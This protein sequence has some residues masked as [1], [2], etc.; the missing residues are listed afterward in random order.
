MELADGD[1]QDSKNIGFNLN[2]KRLMDHKILVYK[3]YITFQ[4][5]NIYNM[6][7]GIPNVT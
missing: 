2:F 4:Y 6:G 7:V 1:R 5:L 3:L